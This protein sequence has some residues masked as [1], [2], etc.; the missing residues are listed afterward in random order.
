MYFLIV[1]QVLKVQHMVVEDNTENVKMYLQVGLFAVSLCFSLMES[2][3]FVP[4]S[5]FTAI[6][7]ILFIMVYFRSI[8]KAFNKMAVMLKRSY[9][10]VLLIFVT[11]FVFGVMATVIFE[12]EEYGSTSSIFLYSFSSL[13][14]SIESLLLLM[15]LENFPEV[16]IDSIGVSVWHLLFLMA[17][18]LIASILV[19]SFVTGV[20]FFHYKRYYVENLNF[21]ETKYP[22]F[23]EC[24]PTVLKKRF[25]DPSYTDTIVQMVEDRERLGS[26][27]EFKLGIR[28]SYKRKLRNAIQKIKALNA[29]K[30]QLYFNKVKEIHQRISISFF[31]RLITFVLCFYQAF[32]PV[33]VIDPNNVADTA[34]FFQA[35]ELVSFVFAIDL[36]LKYTFNKR[37]NFWTFVNVCELASIIGVILFTNLLFIIP[38]D[39][40][41][42][43]PIGS[44]GLYLCWAFASFLKFPRMHLIMME[45]ANYKVI[46]KTCV[47]I[48]PLITDLINMYII[49]ILFYATLGLTMFGGVINTGFPAQFESIAGEELDAA[50]VRLNF[51][52]ISNSIVYLIIMNV[53]YYNTGIQ[54]GLAAATVVNDS[55]LKM[56]FTR[57]YFY[58]F[59]LITELI[60][61]NII[62]GFVI[63]FLELYANNSKD[64]LRREQLIASKQNIIDV[65]L[66]QNKDLTPEEEKQINPELGGNAA[67]SV[68]SEDKRPAKADTYKAP[69]SS[70]SDADEH[71]DSVSDDSIFKDLDR[72]IKE[73]P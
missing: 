25:L 28:A 66:D 57:V 37:R 59:L 63:E 48:I 27:Q 49:V 34:D 29:Q 67:H 23:K 54:K 60:I 68:M 8:L 9:S 36:Y 15:M 73:D 69:I 43:N 20:F 3:N 1:S 58:S 55:G 72:Y 12:A 6:F 46:V 61:I 7:R 14:R 13:S 56:F 44:Y 10:M 16:L 24:V 41:D 33:S 39:Y 4:R 71:E 53:S 2:F 31:Y 11:L 38:V 70:K 50:E 42:T 5:D 35:S 45:Y 65:L 64:L 51:N 17:F 30:K 18:V 22:E 19:I 40:L 52:D 21:V 32:I 26:A 47:H 62:I